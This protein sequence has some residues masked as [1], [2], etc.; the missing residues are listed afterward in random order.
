[1]ITSRA[2]DVLTLPQMLVRM[3]GAGV[4]A[5]VFSLAAWYVLSSISLPAYNTSNVL[6]ALS[7]A[8]LALVVIVACA[9]VW[10][11]V[12]PPRKMA[13]E[14][15]EVTSEKKEG[16]PARSVRNVALPK[17]LRILTQ[18]IAYLAPA[19]LVTA[20]LT[21]PLAATR[22]YL[23]GISVDQG[24]RTQFLTRMT[25]QLSWQD[26]SYIDMPSFY[27]GLWFF[28]GGLFAR[29]TGLEAWA[30]FQPWAILTLSVAGSMLVPVWQRLIG[31]LPLATILSLATTAATL[32]VSAEEPYAAVVAM[33]M[34]AAFVMA[35]RA[36]E[37]G[38]AAIV[39]S[40]VYL[41][42]S[43]NLYTLF[44]GISALTIVIM[45][46][47]VAFLEKS[48]KPLLRVTVIGVSSL[49]IAAIGWGPY[50]LARLTNPAGPNKAQHFLPE[51][52]TQLPLP[53]FD[54][55]TLFILG[56]AAV[57]WLILRFRDPLVHSLSTGLLVCYTWA[58]LSMITTLL[59][60]TLLGFRMSLPI[61]LIF[62]L[63]GVLALADLRTIGLHKVLP[64]TTMRTHAKTFS[65]MLVV[66]LALTGIQYFS[67]TNSA[68][69]ES[70]ELAYEDTDGSAVRGDLHDADD[71]YHYAE[72][73][74]LIQEH[75]GTQ[76]GTVVL[77][78]EK[79]FMS[80]Y[81]YHG[82]QA[83]TAHYAN[84]LGQFDARNATIEAWTKITDPKE[85]LAAMD[86]AEAEHG[87]KHPDAVVL[88]GELDVDKKE[89][90]QDGLPKVKGPGDGKLSYWVADDIYP[91]TPNVRFRKVKFEASAFAE[92][93]ELH[94]VGPFVVAMRT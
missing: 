87:W 84:P 73:D 23:G 91:N 69:R 44:T 56:I 5:A 32:R 92:G 46:L 48:I 83:I 64:R 21:I 8:G 36:M 16:R 37:G 47:L 13:R 12:F 57:V 34:P 66:L 52:G 24:F 30:A 1:M 10:L 15:G 60:T 70:F 25:D 61:T 81:P 43:A 68:E 78:D 93:W 2:T 29:L 74:R 17:W 90:D 76:A 22:L 45:A 27:P 18:A 77:T 41:G 82:Y 42:L 86:A 28:S 35:R 50:L 3:T 38:R 19:A 6:A 11:W 94:Q 26:M 63:G 59:G 51:E 54:N 85:L 39:G 72:I 4:A 89:K 53:F 49:A 65:A 79:N 67:T 7:T 31:S 75:T 33:G 88:R 20:T 71:T 80:Y 62:V 58:L 55:L 40:I 9:A 14:L